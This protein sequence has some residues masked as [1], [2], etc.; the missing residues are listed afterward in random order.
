MYKALCNVTKHHW[1]LFKFPD[2]CFTWLNCIPVLSTLLNTCAYMQLHYTPLSPS[3]LY[4]MMSIVKNVAGLQQI[5]LKVSES[6]EAPLSL[7]RRCP[8]FNDSFAA[9][10]NCVLGRCVEC[11]RRYAIEALAILWSLPEQ[12]HIQPHFA[13]HWTD[14]NVAWE[15]HLVTALL[16]F[17]H[18]ARYWSLDNVIERWEALPF[19]L[20]FDSCSMLRIKTCFE[21]CSLNRNF[22]VPCKLCRMSATQ[23]PLNLVG[24][25][26]IRSNFIRLCQNLLS[27]TTSYQHVLKLGQLRYVFLDFHHLGR[28]LQTAT[29][30]L[31][32]DDLLRS[33]LDQFYGLIE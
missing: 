9:S 21:S 17:K 7:A 16:D 33:F 23:T 32:L 15:H 6:S 25:S 8:S 18:A 28:V 30:C 14:M 4:R 27:L 24:L 29:Q 26:W 22:A 11:N 2:L 13:F 10:T 19:T 3:G 31:K 5:L 1:T 12:D 20:Q